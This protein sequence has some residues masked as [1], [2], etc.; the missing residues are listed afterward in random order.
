MSSFQ[1]TLERAL[2]KSAFARQVTSLA[3]GTVIGQAIVVVTTPLLT[4]LY[5]PAEMGK[6]GLFIAF[7][8]VATLAV[9]L[10]FELAIPAAPDDA[11]ANRL[12]ALSVLFAL[13]LSLL[14]SICLWWMVR[15]NV[16][17]FSL[18]PLW[19]A[20]AVFPALSSMGLFAALRY[21]LVRQRSFRGIGKVMMLQGAGRAT[22]PLAFGFAGLTS[23]GL[24]VGEIVGRM[25]GV[26]E[27]MRASAGSLREG[28]RSITA[29]SLRQE[30]R[31]HWKFPAIVLP[32]SLVDVTALALPAP[33]FAHYYGD[34]SAGLFLLVQRLTFLP[35]SLISASIADV[36]HVRAADSAG[37]SETLTHALYATVR[38]LAKYGVVVLLPAA[39]L[40]PWVFGFIFGGKWA[41][42]GLLV[43]IIAPWAFASLV[44]SPVSRLLVVA[45]RNEWKLLYDV[46]SLTAVSAAVY[47]AYRLGWSFREAVAL[48]SVLQVACFL[49]YF[50][51]LHWAARH[52]GKP[53]A[54]ELPDLETDAP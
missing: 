54:G 28:W 39:I 6:L 8:S 27:M 16:L 44:V 41:D 4:R 7:I 9:T 15:Y 26:G 32:S 24:I 31:R 43:S 22:V 23:A 48:T 2:P 5:S 34:A 1:T 25:V 35:A 19:V 14:G 45:H 42:A 38:G 13:P 52:P 50:V 47:S 20:W 21:W 53:S 40:S 49:F 17:S 12:L 51:L 36:F 30:A 33:L 18:L 37:S 11:A 29:A 46:L 3:S 10:R